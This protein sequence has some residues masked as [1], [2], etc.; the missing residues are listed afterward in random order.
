MQKQ[1][2]FSGQMA[3]QYVSYEKEDP[4]DF[5]PIVR[6]ICDKKRLLLKNLY[7]AFAVPQTQAFLKESSFQD[8]VVAGYTSEN[9]GLKF[10]INSR[11]LF[12][13]V[14]TGLNS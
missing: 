8:H 13:K 1:V 6:F 2:Q 14:V 10:A 11:I 12:G 4:E 9:E 3:R 5:N 7:M